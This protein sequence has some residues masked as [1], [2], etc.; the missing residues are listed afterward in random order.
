M[1]ETVLIENYLVGNLPG[2]EKLLFEAR[3]LIDSPFKEKLENQ[4]L[5]HNIVSSYSRKQ[6]KLEIQIIEQRLFTE[7]RYSKFKN[8]ITQLFNL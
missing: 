3:L 1:N 7:T 4:K 6:F 2:D 8:Q 5:V